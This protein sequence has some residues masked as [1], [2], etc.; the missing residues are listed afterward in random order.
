MSADPQK[1]ATYRAEDRLLRWL[2]VADPTVTVDVT[3]YEPERDER[4]VAPAD[5]QRYV[6]RV[7][8]HLRTSGKDYGGFE[9]QPVT[10]RARQG[11]TKATYAFGVIS[12]PP[13]EVGG[14]WALRAS[15]VLHEI[16]HHL[17]GGD[18]HGA[19]FRATFM[20][21]LEDVGKPVWAELLHL[22]FASEG[23]DAVEHHVAD[24]TVAKVAK[25]LHRAERAL[26]EHERSAF[27]AKAQSLATQHSIAL[28]VARAHTSDEERRDTPI[29]ETVV[30]GEPGRRGLSR[31]VRLLL[32]IAA[33][34][35]LR[36]LISS[37][38]TRV[39]LYG[40]RDDIQ[41]ANALYQSVLVQMVSDCEAFLRS[42]RSSAPTIT[43]RLAFYEGYVLRIGNRL[44]SARDAARQTAVDDA[45]PELSTSTSLALRAKEIE[46]SDAFAEILRK[47]KIRGSWRG[48]QRSS[49]PG[50]RSSYAAGFS[51]GGR[52]RLSDEKALGA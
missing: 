14:S 16:A 22:A 11:K 31:F 34:N 21:L 9:F 7:L 28:A 45:G 25:L 20:R 37:N 42:D 52:A 33:A 18:G 1:L 49:A 26:N 30:I 2:E 13:F 46:V 8:E 44:I 19:S 17:S 50:A 38:S 4:F 51:A 24:D 10:V 6:D 29:E 43:R 27:L 32:N 40:F 15:V 3:S 41:V 5:V 48:A 36:C 23:L 39:F 47:Q 35:D 12:I